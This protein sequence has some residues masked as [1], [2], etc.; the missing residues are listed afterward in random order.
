MAYARWPVTA[1][2]LQLIIA[3]AA[4]AAAAC[5]HG[6]H[7]SPHSPQ[8]FWASPNTSDTNVGTWASGQ[9]KCRSMHVHATLAL[10]RSQAELHWLRSTVLMPSPSDFHWIGLHLRFNGSYG[11]DIY[12]LQPSLTCGHCDSVHRSLAAVYRWRKFHGSNQRL[13]HPRYGKAYIAWLTPDHS[14]ALMEE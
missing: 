10:V 3:A 13:G 1:L 11:L 5:P 2:S 4:V 9:S 7:T 6:W 8:C 12:G 14:N